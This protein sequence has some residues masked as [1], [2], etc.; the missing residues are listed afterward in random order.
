[1]LVCLTGVKAG[2]IGQATGDLL[3]TEADRPCTLLVIK[4][5]ETDETMMLQVREFE[6]TCVSLAKTERK[7][8]SDDLCL[9][10]I[11]FFTLELRKQD[12]K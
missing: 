10:T 5:S 8:E 12:H 3:V 6:Q 4:N 9:C 11:C 2:R 1:M 7:A